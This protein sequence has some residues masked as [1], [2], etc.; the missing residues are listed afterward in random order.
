VGIFGI[1]GTIG[2]GIF[3][4]VGMPG[5]YASCNCPSDH[6]CVSPT[7]A[8][9]ACSVTASFWS[10]T[11]S[12]LSFS[13]NSL[14]VFCKD[15]SKRGEYATSLADVARAACGKAMRKNVQANRKDKAKSR[16]DEDRVRIDRYK[17][18]PSFHYNLHGMLFRHP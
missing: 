18:H 13:E 16:H 9:S 14:R 2:V 5:V 3:G 4:I 1:V 8:L 7:S 6:V 15:A 10:L 11:N 12:P 17:I